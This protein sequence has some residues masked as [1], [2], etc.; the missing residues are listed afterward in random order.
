[1]PVCWDNHLQ[2]GAKR[3]YFW[4]F[5]VGVLGRVASIEMEM[6]LR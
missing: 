6:V 5:A 1:M 3:C 2:S 4:C